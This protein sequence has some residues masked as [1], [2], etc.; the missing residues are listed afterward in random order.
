MNSVCR[1]REDSPEIADVDRFHRSGFKLWLESFV[2]CTEFVGVSSLPPALPS[3]DISFGVLCT[4]LCT[5]VVCVSR[6]GPTVCRAIS[7]CQAVA[8][9]V[10]GAGFLAAK[11]HS[12]AGF[13]MQCTHSASIT[14]VVVPGGQTMCGI[15]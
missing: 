5:S 9:H 15:N 8:R 6:V 14:R 12:F 11:Q 2:R 3:D 1:R 4:V 13:P 7:G 10:R